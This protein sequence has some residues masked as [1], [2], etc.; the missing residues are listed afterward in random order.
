MLHSPDWHVTIIYIHSYGGESSNNSTKFCL[1]H[2]PFEGS[3]LGREV[4]GGG[5]LVRVPLPPRF[6]DAR[7]R[8]GLAVGVSSGLF[9]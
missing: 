5:T 7:G 2:T 8:E 9:F 3:L 1:L 4:R 6:L